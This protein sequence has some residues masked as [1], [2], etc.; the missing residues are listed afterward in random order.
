MRDQEIKKESEPKILEKIPVE[1]TK[2]SV[3]VRYLH[4]I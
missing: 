4:K 2:Q 3:Q 1:E